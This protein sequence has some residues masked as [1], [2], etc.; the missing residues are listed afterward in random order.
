MLGVRWSHALIAM[1]FIA[2]LLFIGSHKHY[3]ITLIPLRT[4]LI[5][6]FKSYSFSCL[7]RYILIDNEQSNDLSST[8]INK[9]LAVRLEGLF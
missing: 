5:A 7:F 9:M 4:S 3:R 1:P 2:F 8:K 6:L